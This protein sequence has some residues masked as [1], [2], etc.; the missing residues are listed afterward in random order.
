[1]LNLHYNTKLIEVLVKS[2]IFFHLTNFFH[3]AHLPSN[4]NVN[5][6]LSIDQCFFSIESP[7]TLKF[8]R[9]IFNILLDEDEEK[10]RQKIKNLIQKKINRNNIAVNL[11]HLI[12]ISQWLKRI[13][14]Y[15]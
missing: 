14:I 10:V 12:T 15:N 6:A 9:A 1:M 13:G 2:K 7:H 8:N 3:P 5:L 4:F 11:R